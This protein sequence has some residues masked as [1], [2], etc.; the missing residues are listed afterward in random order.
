MRLSIPKALSSR[1]WLLVVLLFGSFLAFWVYFIN[2][3]VKNQPKMIPLAP[4][5]GA[6]S[7][8]GNH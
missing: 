3:A 7:A 4:L 1:P 2:I 8:D 6:A 5:P